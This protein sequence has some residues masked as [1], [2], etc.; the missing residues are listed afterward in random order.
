MII[1]SV[2]MTSTI[3]LLTASMGLIAAHTATA[4][5]FLRGTH[6]NWEAEPMLGQGY[7]QGRDI[8]TFKDCDK[9][10]FKFDTRGD[11]SENFGDFDNVRGY[12]PG[13][14]AMEGHLDQGGSNIEVE[15]GK[16]YFIEMSY[17][18]SGNGNTYSLRDLA[19]DVPQT[20]AVGTDASFRKAVRGGGFYGSVSIT[21]ELL[22]RDLPG[23]TKVV[24]R[25]IDSEGRTIVG[26]ASPYKPLSGGLSLWRFAVGSYGSIDLQSIELQNNG[27]SAA[28]EINQA[29][30]Q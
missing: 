2:K 20:L 21:G 23:E 18:S 1:N 10:A 9:V 27:R 3:R 14:N 17:Y 25:A 15:C 12:N 8:L 5:V 29:L 6:N 28:L 26:E 30:I 4:D 16:T 19:A 13:I 24:V 11:W 22:V 7:Y